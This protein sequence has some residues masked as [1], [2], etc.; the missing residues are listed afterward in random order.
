VRRVAR[1][2]RARLHRR[3]FVWFGVSILFTL[4]T[5][6]TAA[7]LVA[8]SANPWRTMFIRGQT[9]VGGQLALVWH[10]AERRDALLSAAARDLEIGL[11][12]EDPQGN[13]IA[14]YGPACKRPD[15]WAPVLSGDRLLGHV[16]ACGSRPPHRGFLTL[17]VV[18]GV[19][20]LTLWGASGMISRRLVRPLGEL[21]R[22]A[23][24]IGSGNLKARTTLAQ[25]R[26]GEVGELGEAI[27]DMAARI[28]RQMADQRELLAA[29]SHEI[30]SPLSRM[31]VLLELARERADAATIDELEREVVEVDSLVGQLLASS[32]LDFAALDKR[33]LDARDAG[34]RSLERAGLPADLFQVDA[35]R[36]EIEA[37]P[38]L[39]ARALDNLLENARKHGGGVTALRVF[40][41]GGQLAFAVED[42]GAGFS[43]GD[44][45]RVFESFVRGE[46]SAGSSLGLG[47]ALVRRIAR[48]HGGD[49]WAENR[50]DG[51]ARV[52][53]T[54]SR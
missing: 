54:L 5:V 44:V 17:F 7:W 43:D 11:E 28:E 27:N 51:G 24:A 18:L 12:L 49:A 31:R 42:R 40:S 22:V 1:F 53:F 14:S 25:H 33:P 8:P 36:T 21:V 32:R 26:V 9:F 45:E 4:L 38:T 50:E 6:G 37:D 3:L 34:Q 23:N 48:A 15:F 52:G 35:D 39:L 13:R 41:R 20:G 29:V 46:R 16:R 2:V 47:L 19:G 10:D 30:R